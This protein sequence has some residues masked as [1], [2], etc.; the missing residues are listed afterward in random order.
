MW[1][2]APYWSQRLLGLSPDEYRLILKS[3]PLRLQVINEERGK[4]VGRIPIK[5]VR[6]ISLGGVEVV[7]ESGYLLDPRIF[8]DI[9]R[10][11][12]IL[13]A[14]DQGKRP[15]HFDNSAYVK[16]LEQD[17]VGEKV[18]HLDLDFSRWFS[19]KGRDRNVE[20]IRD[21]VVIDMKTRKLLR[22]KF[23]YPLAYARWGVPFT[24]GRGRFEIP[25]K[26]S[27]FIA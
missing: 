20:N 12:R 21:G 2:G 5:D 10:E 4:V 23:E 16:V 19:V 11:D 17:M 15:S 18:L 1:G 27:T 26:T 14:A 13:A 24:P 8:S 9:S 6:Y 3:D 25:T 22:R 7:G